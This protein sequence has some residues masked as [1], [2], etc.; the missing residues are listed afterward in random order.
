LA[1]PGLIVA[2]RKIAERVKAWTT[3]CGTGGKSAC[4]LGVVNGSASYRT[5]SSNTLSDTPVTAGV[6]NYFLK[7][8]TISVHW[9]S[10]S[11]DLIKIKKT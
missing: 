8:C 7:N 1:L 2:T 6:G 9:N 4:V 5:D 3:G 10:A 11:K